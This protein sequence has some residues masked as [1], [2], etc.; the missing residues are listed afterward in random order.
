MKKLKRPVSAEPILI[1]AEALH[2]V[3]PPCSSSFSGINELASGLPL[4]LLGS[5]QG[6]PNQAHGFKSF[7]VP[8][9]KSF[10]WITALIVFFS[11]CALGK[12]GLLLNFYLQSCFS[13]LVFI[14]NSV[15]SN[16]LLVTGV[17][18]GPAKIDVGELVLVMTPTFPICLWARAGHC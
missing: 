4:L 17:S 5:I 7:C 18:L 8:F 15:A 13:F 16:Q 3:T 6:L 2:A 11:F 12:F 9:C 1:W 14:I 10:S